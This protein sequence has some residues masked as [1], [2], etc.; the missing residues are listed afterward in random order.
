VTDE[1][2]ERR[3]LSH[4]TTFIMLFLL[5]CFI[6]LVVS[7][8]GYINGSWDP[9][10]IIL[11]FSATMLASLLS[12][13]IASS[14]ML[15]FD[16]DFCHRNVDLPFEELIH[17]I[18]DAVEKTGIKYS[19]YSTSEYKTRGANVKW[20]REPTA[21]G[22]NVT[23]YMKYD[24]NHDDQHISVVGRKGDPIETAII[25]IYHNDEVDHMLIEGLTRNINQEIA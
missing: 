22:S 1:W 16:Y 20:R 12:I 23:G 11:F 19:R 3:R 7:V 6:T 13:A 15:G 2:S 9:E 14:L 5:W 4:W 10:P 17:Q 18:D 21:T 8:V 25:V 24:L